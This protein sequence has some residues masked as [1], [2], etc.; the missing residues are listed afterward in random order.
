[1]TITTKGPDGKETSTP[2]TYEVDGDKLTTTLKVGDKEAKQTLTI[3]KLTDSE[4]S[5]KDEKG[6]TDEYKKK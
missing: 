1:M 4:M 2:G 3:T 6:K 5:T